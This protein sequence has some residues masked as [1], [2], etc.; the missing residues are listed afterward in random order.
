MPEK[1][2]NAYE[3]SREKLEVRNT[4]VGGIGTPYKRPTGIPQCD[5]FSM[6]V[7]ASAWLMQMK[8]AAV[9]PRILVDDLQILARGPNHLERLDISQVLKTI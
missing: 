7:I 2:L 9:K 8:E 1:V 6:M 4:I 3:N 5:L